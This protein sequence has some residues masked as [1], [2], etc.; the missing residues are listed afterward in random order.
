MGNKKR[1]LNVSS[2]SSKSG[3]V[4]LNIAD[5]EK[6]D[7]QQNFDTKRINSDMSAAAETVSEAVSTQG[8]EYIRNIEGTIEN[9]DLVYHFTGNLHDA[10]VSDE[11][12]FESYVQSLARRRSQSLESRPIQVTNGSTSTSPMETHRLMKEGFLKVNR[13]RM[14]HACTP[15][16]PHQTAHPRKRYKA[17]VYKGAS[18]GNIQ[19]SNDIGDSLTCSNVSEICVDNAESCVIEN[20]IIEIV[21]CQGDLN[22]QVSNDMLRTDK[23]IANVMNSVEIAAVDGLR[24]MPNGVASNLND[25]M[26]KEVSHSRTINQSR[27]PL[28]EEQRN[29]LKEVQLRTVFIGGHKDDLRKYFKHMPRQLNKEILEK[30]KGSVDNI[31][32][33]QKGVLKIISKDEAQKNQLLKIQSL[34]DKP[35][36]TSIPFCLTVPNE[37]KSEPP[38]VKA[39][40]TEYFVKGVV[41]GLLENQE[42]LDEIALEVKAHH[43]FRLGNQEF[44]KATLIAYPKETV[45]PEFLEVDGRRYKV[46][47]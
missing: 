22:S 2:G 28:T 30:T 7:T 29:R 5:K 41:F 33:T 16:E 43:I 19:T 9:T 27:P 42:N 26:T 3:D 14:F 40:E 35:V 1:S 32:L 21:T 11:R 12:N 45:L 17:N 44:S 46:H 15:G 34:N 24:L 20:N 4:S 23:L 47:P 18:F 10:S 13:P 6:L 31:V 36:K 37:S 25:T 38:P 39:P 8:A